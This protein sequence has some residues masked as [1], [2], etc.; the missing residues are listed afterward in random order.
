M[1][2]FEE[3]SLTTIELAAK[4]GRGECHIFDISTTGDYSKT[5]YKKC[6]NKN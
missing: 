5:L 3:S 6:S 4:F 1:G 2:L